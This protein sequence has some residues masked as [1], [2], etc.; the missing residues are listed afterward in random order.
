MR[1]GR[2]L[3]RGAGPVAVLSLLERRERYGYEL[4]EALEART[5]GVLGMGQSTLYPLLYNLEAK[6]LI[7]G[8]WKTAVSGRRR[9]YYRLTSAGRNHLE[10]HRT[11]WQQLVQAMAQL[12][13]VEPASEG[14]AASRTS[15]E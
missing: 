6:K 10:T 13:L 14:V 7:V 3:M 8:R 2:E 11:Q 1:V 5:D 9:K 4:V 15:E 12:G